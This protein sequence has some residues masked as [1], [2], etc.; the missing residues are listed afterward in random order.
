MELFL[1]LGR[2]CVYLW[3]GPLWNTGSWP[4]S[5]SGVT[6]H[7][8]QIC[9]LW[10]CLCQTNISVG[11]RG[12][13]EWVKTKWMCAVDFNMARSGTSEPQTRGKMAKRVGLRGKRKCPPL[14]HVWILMVHRKCPP[15]L[16]PPPDIYI[17][18]TASL[19]TLLLLRLVKPAPFDPGVHH[20][21]CF[22]VYLN[23]ITWHL[24]SACWVWW[25][26]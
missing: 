22:L 5:Q 18:K 23:V 20:K 19:Q 21:L 24:C 26:P 9:C 17:L 25:L 1:K 10:K 12:S 4:Q 2:L 13:S 11:N 15:R 8:R 14:V 6:G 16:S 3:T 7:S